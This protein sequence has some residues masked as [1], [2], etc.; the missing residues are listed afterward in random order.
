MVVAK[1]RKHLFSE[2]IETLFMLAS[3]KLLS[4]KL[5]EYEEEI[6]FLEGHLKWLE[7]NAFILKLFYILLFC[8]SSA[9][10]N[11]LHTKCYFFFPRL[12]QILWE[13][14]YRYD[15]RGWAWQKRGGGGCFWGGL[16]HQY[17]LWIDLKSGNQRYPCLSF[18]PNLETEQVRETK[19]GTNVSNKMLLHAVK[20]KGHSFYHLLV[21]KG[22]PTGG[23]ITP[24]PNQIRVNSMIEE[25]SIA[26][27]RE[28]N[29]LTKN[30]Q[31]LKKTMKF[32]RTLL[33]IGSVIMIILIL[34][35][36]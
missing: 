25:S 28:T 12:P 13:P 18:T 36:K 24:P 8:F 11:H 4:R 17:T 7:F 27:K 30:L 14:E 23:K 3:L 20:C 31:W 15:L 2:N 6:K 9:C 33:N 34:I 19:F 22:N 29:I 1:Q 21:I 5:S 32:L 10:E 26:V 16:I 35:L